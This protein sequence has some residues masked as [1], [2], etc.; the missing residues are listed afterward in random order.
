MIDFKKLLSTK[1][2]NEIAA[3]DE[4]FAERLIETRA[5]TNANLVS[6]IKYFTS[7]MDTPR[8]YKPGL[9]V[10]DATFWHV[11]LPELLTRVERKTK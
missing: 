2:Q 3:Q 7:Q 5:M 1:R 8:K 4:F 6:T 11:L 9:P 10:Y